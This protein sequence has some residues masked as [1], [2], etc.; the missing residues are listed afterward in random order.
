MPSDSV[1]VTGSGGYIG[2][3]VGLELQDHGYDVIGVDR[4]DRPISRYWKNIQ[5][6]FTSSETLTWITR[7]QPSTIV[8]CAGTSLVGP[9]M[10]DPGEYYRNNVAR[11]IK[12]LEHVRQYSPHTRV[13]FASSA[14]TY[15]EP[16]PA[17]VP[18]QESAP[19]T[20]ISPY[21]HSKLMVEQI[22]ADYHAA[23]GL[24]YVAFRFFNVCGADPQKRHGQEN[25]AT[26]IVARVCE[27][28]RDNA[29][30]RLNGNDYNT[31]DGTCIR[32]YVHVSDIASAIRFAITRKDM[33][34]VFN[35]G[36]AH[37]HSNQEI[38]Q[39]AER[40]TG[41]KLDWQVGPRRLGDPDRLTA[42]PEK[43]NAL[44]WKS[45]FDLDDM[46]RHAWQWYVR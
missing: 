12:L 6:G 21:G 24:G 45:S 30:F 43:L 9:S 31:P 32:D 2:G 1:L 4:R 27:S 16:D 40:I 29:V 18:L 13:I 41:Q 17:L 36:S 8:H 33:N 28:L 3:Q 20:P 15:G 46:I 25:G 14:A 7:N 38:M 44:N 22:L 39:A 10:T 34:G 26:H 37:G 19:T 11:T 5:A 23:Y 35:I 42:S